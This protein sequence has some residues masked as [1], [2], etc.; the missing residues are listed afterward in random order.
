MWSPRSLP[1]MTSMR[2]KSFESVECIYI[3]EEPSAY[4]MAN[5]Y[6][7]SCKNIYDTRKTML[8]YTVSAYV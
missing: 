5:F 4:F 2:K 1:G 3:F 7:S 6:E 8:L